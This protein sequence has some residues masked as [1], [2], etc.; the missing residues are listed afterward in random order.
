LSLCELLLRQYYLLL[1]LC[2]LLL[3]RYVLLPSLSF[4]IT[5]QLNFSKIKNK[6]LYFELEPI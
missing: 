5:N 1:S 3:S 2:E 4:V 6:L